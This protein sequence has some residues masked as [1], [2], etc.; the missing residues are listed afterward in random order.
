MS[1]LSADILGTSQTT[2]IGLIL[3]N[4][5]W[6][7]ILWTETDW[8]FFYLPL[9]LLISTTYQQD[10]QVSCESAAVSWHFQCHGTVQHSLPQILV[11][12]LGLPCVAAQDAGGAGQNFAGDPGDPL[13]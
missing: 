6:V 3:L 12:D 4:K 2:S 9:L 8:T 10:Q 7:L 5:A 13:W 1:K 11:D